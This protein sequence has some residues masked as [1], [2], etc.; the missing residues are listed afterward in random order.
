MTKLKLEPPIYRIGEYSY[1]LTSG[2][3]SKNNHL[4]RLR[5]KESALLNALIEQFPEVLSRENIVDKLYENT[6]ATDATINQLVKRL[7]KALGDEERSLIRTIPK[8]GYMLTVAPNKIETKDASPHI[9]AKYYG[10]IILLSPSTLTSR[11]CP[12]PLGN[13]PVPLPLGIK[14]GVYQQYSLALAVH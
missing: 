10:G 2:V 13:Y 9:P 11:N 4:S 6:Y 5:A 12:K 14:R 8:K 7:R 3:V 1:S